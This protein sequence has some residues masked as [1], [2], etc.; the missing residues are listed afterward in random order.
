MKQF[1]IKLA[2]G[3]VAVAS[4]IFYV[5][6]QQKKN[7]D[8]IQKEAELKAE[9][10]KYVEI[11]KKVEQTEQF[12]KAA[13]EIKVEEEKKVEEE[14]KEVASGNKLSNFNAGLDLLRK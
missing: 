8:H 6:F 11:C 10:E 9:V 2:A 5:L 3:V 14:F 12:E 13:E 1:F 7:E 4:A